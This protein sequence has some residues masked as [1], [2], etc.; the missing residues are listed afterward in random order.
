MMPDACREWRGALASAALGRIDP[1]H[2]RTSE[3]IG[4]CAHLDGC[5]VCRGELAELKA[6]ARALPE[7]DAATLAS[8]PVEP[9]GSLGELVIS[10][11]AK[12]RK[13][14]H[15]R[16]RHIGLFAAAAALVVALALAGS[17][18]ALRPTHARVTHVAFESLAEGH[19]SADLTSTAAGTKVDFTVSGLHGGDWYWLWLTGSDG[20]RIPAGSFRGAGGH[21]ELNLTAALP[22]EKTERVWV[23]DDA[24]AVVFD[25][26]LDP[27]AK[28]ASA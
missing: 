7:A 28:P 20:K 6:V 19:A 23:T 2:A 13:R 4:L 3:E 15:T 12:E 1:F 5:P 16:R 21:S 24:D 27:S 25:A 22:L 9:A 11:V 18:V 14:R 17:F 26:W 8:D 10:G